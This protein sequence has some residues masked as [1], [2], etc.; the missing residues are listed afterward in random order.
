MTT[1]QQKENGVPNRCRECRQTLSELE[2]LRE[3]LCQTRLCWECHF[4]LGKRD[5]GGLVIDGEHYQV[6]PED[7]VFP[8]RGSRG[9]RFV[10]ET[11]DGR[12]IETTNLWWQGAIPPRFRKLFPDNARIIERSEEH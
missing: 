3:E 9:R 2:R 8:F 1:S 11:N 4:W 10:I 5:A 12:K 7:A 6:G